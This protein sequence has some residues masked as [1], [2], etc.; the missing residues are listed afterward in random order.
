VRL[1]HRRLADGEW[2]ELRGLLVTR[3]CRI[4]SDL[5]TERAD[6]E[7]VAQLVTDAIRAVDDYPGTF[8]DALA[9]HAVHFGLRRNDGLALLRWLLDLVGDSETSAWMDEA[10]EHTDRAAKREGSSRE[11]TGQR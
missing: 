7:S 2:I 3:P 11:R 4:A 6:P 10:R 9:P 5:L 8:A 1:H